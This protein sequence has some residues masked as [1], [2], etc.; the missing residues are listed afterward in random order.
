MS[1]YDPLNS[2][3]KSH[4]NLVVPMSFA[5]IERI[6]GFAL[7]ASAYEYPAWW[8]NHVSSHVQAQAWA[9]AG[10]QVEQL[11][12]A[13]KKVVFKRGNPM[14]GVSERPRA[15]ASEEPASSR[16]PVI[17]A[18]K[19][20]FTIELGTDLTAPAMPEWADLIDEKY[21]KGNGA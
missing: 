20:T 9:N 10:Y 3:L 7:P 11:D 19:G 21:G 15:F 2:H 13:A 18:L 12:L 14:R 6:L 4:P 1:K 17:G 16:H 5:Q 8:S